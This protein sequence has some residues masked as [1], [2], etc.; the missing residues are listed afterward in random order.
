MMKTANLRPTSLVP[1]HGLPPTYGLLGLN[2]EK[3]G[4]AEAMDAHK[5]SAVQPAGV[6]HNPQSVL[7]DVHIT[8]HQREAA[9]LLGASSTQQ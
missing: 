6:Q 2:G 5:A 9:F 7:R 8:G 1:N 4:G 3:E